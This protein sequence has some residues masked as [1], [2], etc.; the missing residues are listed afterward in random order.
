M[1]RTRI[2]NQFVSLDGFSAGDHVTLDHPIGDAQALFGGFDG[3]FIG[4]V[5]KVDAPITLDGAL[6]SLWGQGIG[7]EI[8]GRRKFGPQSGEWPDDGWKGW[9]DDAPPFETPVFVLTHHPRESIEFSNGTVFHF[10]DA[11]PEE[12][13]TRATEAAD[14]GDV[15]IGGGPSTV[16]QFLAADLVDFMHVVTVPITLGR[17]VRLW[18]DV[19]GVEDRFTIESVTSA[20]GRIHQLW[21]RKPRG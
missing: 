12:A 21:N 11:S 15:R 19:A 6:T 9:W 18:D 17:G 1:S 2:H 8:M 13:L 20:S 7:A 3:R 14:G 16:K 4:G 10:I 5:D